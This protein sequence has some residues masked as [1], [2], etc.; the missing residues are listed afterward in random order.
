MEANWPGGFLIEVTEYDEPVAQSAL[1]GLTGGG[2]A[3]LYTVTVA[4]QLP[5]REKCKNNTSRNNN[6]KILNRN[7][8]NF[9]LEHRHNAGPA[10][11]TARALVISSH[12]F[13]WARSFLQSS[14][15]L[16]SEETSATAGVGVSLETILILGFQVDLCSLLPPTEFQVVFVTLKYKIEGIFLIKI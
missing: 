2:A 14:P 13:L 10:T 4:G 15:W 8:Q 3:A 6:C 5:E 12:S 11:A 7:P 9:P 1:A 16:R